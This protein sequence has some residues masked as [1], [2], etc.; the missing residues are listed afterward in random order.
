MFSM[1]LMLLLLVRVGLFVGLLVVTG[2]EE[3]GGSSDFMLLAG[4]LANLEGEELKANS[5]LLLLKYL[6]VELVEQ[7]GLLPIGIGIGV[8]FWNWK[9]KQ[10]YFLSSSLLDSSDLTTHPE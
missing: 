7:V 1:L 10:Q 2:E 9:V 5:I 6:K 8:G 4:L 3:G